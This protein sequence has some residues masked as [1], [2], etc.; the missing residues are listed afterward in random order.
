MGAKVAAA[1]A[2]R[3]KQR[4][5]AEAKDAKRKEIEEKGTSFFAEHPGITCDG[6]GETPLFGYRY[7]C[8]W[9]T[10]HDICESCY[11]TWAGGH[12]TITNGLAKQAL[13]QNAKDHTFYLYKDSGSKQVVTGKTGGQ[14]TA[15]TKVKPNDP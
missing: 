5:I 11:D 10:N 3:E 6:C 4:L 14:K 13:S 2:E 12:G 1:K 9:C 7:R 15:S 8:K